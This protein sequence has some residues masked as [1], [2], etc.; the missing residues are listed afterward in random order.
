M[1]VSELIKDLQDIRDECGGHLPVY[2]PDGEADIVYLNALTDIDGSHLDE[3]IS[4]DPVN[5]SS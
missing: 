2:L 1:T 3:F 5:P 4:I